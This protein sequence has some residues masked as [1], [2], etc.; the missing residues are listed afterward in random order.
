MEDRQ[1]FTE[2]LL[3]RRPGDSSAAEYAGDADRQFQQVVVQSAKTMI[4]LGDVESAKRLLREANL[5][6]LNDADLLHYRGMAHADREA[7][8][9]AL[10]D[11]DAALRLMPGHHPA[12]LSRYLA[13]TKL[14]QWQGAKDDFA[15]TIEFTTMD[16]RRAPY[17]SSWL[18]NWS[19]VNDHFTKAI[20]KEGAK[21]WLSRARI[22]SL[23]AMG[24]FTRGANDCKEA[25]ALKDND[26]ATWHLHG[27]ILQ[28]QGQVERSIAAFTRAIDLR[29]SGWSSWKARAFSYAAVKKWDLAI[30]DCTK[31]IELGDDCWSTWNLRGRAH[32]FV[33]EPEKAS[34][35]LTQAARLKAQQVGQ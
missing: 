25:L 5:A 34:A 10:A 8:H 27:I 30:A 29:A 31:T 17:L 20:E 9:E 12:R 14:G 11:Y 2:G 26:W 21:W 33:N 4:H 24:Q 28:R 35:D 15:R 22:V 7:W 13:K 19:A 6:Q 18:A 16:R 3:A 32:S 1:G 23:V